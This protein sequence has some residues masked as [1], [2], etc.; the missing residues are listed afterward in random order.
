MSMTLQQ[1]RRT[2]TPKNVNFRNL[3]ALPAYLA[4][5]KLHMVGAL[6]ALLVTSLSVLGLGKGLGYLIDKGFGDGGNPALLNTA[7]IFLIGITLV[8]AIGTFARFFLVTYV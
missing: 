1:A 2:E 4:P 8:L 7:L 3:K 5:Y 6:L